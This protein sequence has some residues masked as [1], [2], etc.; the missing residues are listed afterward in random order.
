MGAG[1]FASKVER[2]M[3]STRG[4]Y[5]SI[6]GYRQEVVD[7]VSTSSSLILMDGQDLTLILEGRVSLVEALRVKIN[8]ASREGIIFYS[9]SRLD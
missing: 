2:R 3:K 7:E 5:V 1:G 4:L 8:K 9:L 6:A